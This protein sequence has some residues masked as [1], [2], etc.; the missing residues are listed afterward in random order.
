[1]HRFPMERARALCADAAA[2]ASR[3]L[4]D[5]SLSHA[6]AGLAAAPRS[7]LRLRRAL[8]NIAGVAHHLAGEYDPAHEHLQRALALAEDCGRHGASHDAYVDLAGVLGDLAANSCMRT[9]LEDAAIALKR[10]RFMLQRA[11]QPSAAAQTCLHNV[12]GWVAFARGDFEAALTSHQEAHTLITR[13]P[14]HSGVPS[15]WGH[16]ALGGSIAA[17][18]ALQRPRAAERLAAVAVQAVEVDELDPRCAPFARSNAALAAITASGGEPTPAAA[19]VAA[20]RLEQVAAE[21]QALLGPQHSTTR[22]A[23]SNATLALTGA[24]VGS[25]MEPLFQPALGAGIADV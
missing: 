15:A 8:H 5:S 16:A 20:E 14:A 2:A 24:S 1:M 11:H 19:R 23:R 21:L 17:L 12:T 10:G 3:T 22:Q 9:E 13:L 7:A 6:E 4:F 25:G 18:I